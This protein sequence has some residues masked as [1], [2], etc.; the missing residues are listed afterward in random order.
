MEVAEEV[1]TARVAGARGA[2]EAE[3]AGVPGKG[4]FETELEV[5]IGQVL[6]EEPIPRPRC[7]KPRGLES[8]AAQC[9]S[10]EPMPTST[11]PRPCLAW[12]G[13]LSSPAEA[14]N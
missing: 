10:S 8:Q 13:G 2:V 4:S 1:V 6:R 3:A 11:G 5:H 9:R 12:L 14:S 7:A